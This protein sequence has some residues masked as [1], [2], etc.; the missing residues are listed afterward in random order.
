MPTY[1]NNTSA[2]QYIDNNKLRFVDPGD[3][4]ETFKIVNN[5]KLTKIS[6]EPY[7][8]PLLE[9]HKPTG[10]ADYEI[11]LNSDTRKVEVYNSSDYDIT[12]YLNTKSNTPGIVCPSSTV[13]NIEEIKD[14]VSD[15]IFDFG[16]SISANEV[17]I[18]EYS[19]K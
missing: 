5:D 15:M 9:V 12:V 8:N 18:S 1:K 16:G 4:Y 10:S 13:R 6:D 7:Y 11:S 3:T 2:K 19:K 17:I 14:V